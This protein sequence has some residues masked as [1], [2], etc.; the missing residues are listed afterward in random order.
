MFSMVNVA[1]I[2]QGISVLITVLVAVASLLGIFNPQTYIKETTNWAL[3]ARGQDI[4]NLLAIISLLVSVYFLSKKSLKAYF[5]WLGVLFYLIYAYLIYSF[6]AHFNFLFLVY[7]AILGLSIYTLIGGLLGQNH[8]I[9]LKKI[10]YNSKT[11]AAA[12]LLI[13]IGVL[14]G[15]LWLSEIARALFTGS[16]PQSLVNTGLL[17]NPVHVIDLSVVLPGLIITGI[18]F[19]KKSPLGYLF[20]APWLMFSVLMGSSII[21]TTIMMLLQGSR[22]ALLPLLSIS[23][24]VVI[25]LIMLAVYFREVVEKKY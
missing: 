18:L 11:K 19:L 15:F 12:I 2:W 8:S 25:S 9:L 10:S 21:V 13:V 14:F 5:V 1:E 16:I 7:V 3:Q 6:A 22:E 23:I 17:V 24:I 4:G 20:T